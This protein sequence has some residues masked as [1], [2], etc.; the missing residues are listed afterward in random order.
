MIDKRKDWAKKQ[1]LHFDSLL[2][3]ARRAQSSDLR[4]RMYAFLGLGNSG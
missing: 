2:H 1:K 4:D 3:Y